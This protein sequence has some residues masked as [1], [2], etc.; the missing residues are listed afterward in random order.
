M[1]VCLMVVLMAGFGLAGCGTDTVEEDPI[2]ED[3]VDNGDDETDEDNGDETGEGPAF[4][5]EVGDVSVAAFLAIVHDAIPGIIIVGLE[6]ELVNNGSAVITAYPENA[7]L[8]TCLDQGLAANEGRSGRISTLGVNEDAVPPFGE[9]EPGE[10]A[11]AK[12]IWLVPAGETDFDTIKIT[13]EV[14]GQD[15]VIELDD[16]DAY[17]V[18]F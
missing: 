17:R 7:I 4:V 11:Y 1:L 16:L 14:G 3:P 12:H 13:F 9:I 18:Y 15:L 6:Y 2:D 10:T 8:D 5:G